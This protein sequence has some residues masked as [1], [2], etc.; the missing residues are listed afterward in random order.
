VNELEKLLNK[1]LS[2]TNYIKMTFDK[3]E[4]N[5]HVII[6]FTVQDSDAKRNQRTSEYELKK[7]VRK[8]L[9]NTNW[10]L[11]TDGVNY[12]L[13]YLSGRLKGYENQEDLMNLVNK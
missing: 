2:K 10:R 8:T 13:G 12:R 3:P 4:I 11:M 7:I 6:P 9:L 1:S 5:Q